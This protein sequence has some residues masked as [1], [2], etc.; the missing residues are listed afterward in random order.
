MQPPDY[1][2]P[3]DLLATAMH[4]PRER[5]NARGKIAIDAP[6]LRM[7]LQTLASLMPF[8]EAFYRSAYPDI[9]EAAATGRLTDLHQH[10][11]ETGYFEG[12]LGAMPDLDEKFY[13]ANNPDVAVAIQRG[14][15]A[16]AG[17]HYVR[18]G[19]AEGR[20]P[21]AELLPQVEAWMRLLKIALRP[22]V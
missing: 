10:F 9:A 13:L 20:A 19:A 3:I 11:V 17:A 12:R 2:P 7:M 21:S 4:I 15:V 16:S 1:L 5:L 8:S 14:D 6:L 22:E 18:A